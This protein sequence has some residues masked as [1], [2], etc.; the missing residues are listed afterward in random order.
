MTGRRRRVPRRGRKG[1]GIGDERLDFP[2]GFELFGADDRVDLAKQCHPHDTGRGI[3][4]LTANP[5]G[6]DRLPDSRGS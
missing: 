4:P 5:I 1:S 2:S 3:E 6:I